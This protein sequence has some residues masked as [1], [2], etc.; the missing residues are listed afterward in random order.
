[1]RLVGDDGAA[2]VAPRPGG[3]LPLLAGAE[4]YY[5]NTTAANRFL[6]DLAAVPDDVW[7]RCQL[8]FLCSPAAGYISGTILD[9]DGGS[10]IGDA[11]RGDLAGGMA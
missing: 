6:P 5:L 1:M 8:L 10:K 11:S 9:C 4:P 2:R 3:V 7:Q